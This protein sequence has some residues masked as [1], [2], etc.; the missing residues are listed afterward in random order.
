MLSFILAACN[1]IDIMFML[2]NSG[3][4]L[5]PNAG[6][7]PSNFAHSVNFINNIAASLGIDCNRTQAGAILF[8]NNGLIKIKLNE[9]CTTSS[10]QTAVNARLLFQNQRANLAA[11]L[12]SAAQSFNVTNGGRTNSWK[13]VIIIYGG[14]MSS[15][16]NPQNGTEQAAALKAVADD[17]YVFN[18]DFFYAAGLATPDL[19]LQMAS[20][21]Y[22]THLY[23]L[24]APNYSFQQFADNYVQVVKD[25]IGA[26]CNTKRIGITPYSGSGQCVFFQCGYIIRQI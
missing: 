4:I 23:T 11:G 15:S 14:E 7:I 25:Q 9:F 20:T 22:S 18:T 8:G 24:T 26:S 2:D 3:N 21:P 12:V 1:N 17:I 10:F 5:S 19:A 6:A 16:S 13:V